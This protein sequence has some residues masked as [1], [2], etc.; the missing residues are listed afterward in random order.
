MEKGNFEDKMPC[1]CLFFIQTIMITPCL[2]WE[3]SPF[4]KL[5]GGEDKWETGTVEEGGENVVDI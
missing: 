5:V 2:P 1:S 3:A 4:L